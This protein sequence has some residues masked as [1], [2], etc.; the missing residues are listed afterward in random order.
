M[1]IYLPLPRQIRAPLEEGEEILSGALI[2]TMN[3]E[4]GGG[5]KEEEG[6]RSISPSH[7]IYGLE[8]PVVDDA[9]ARLVARM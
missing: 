7:P 8:S 5:E 4:R 6:I 3:K 1:Y 9:A 2:D